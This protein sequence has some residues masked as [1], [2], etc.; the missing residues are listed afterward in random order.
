MCDTTTGFY[1]GD[2]KRCSTCDSHCPH[3]DLCANIM[4]VFTCY[5]CANGKYLKAGTAGGLAT[6]EACGAGCGICS[7]LTTCNMCTDPS[8]YCMK[9]W[10]QTT[11]NTVSGF[12]MMC[13]MCKDVNCNACDASSDTCTACKAGFTLASGKCSLDTNVNNLPCP[14][15]FYKATG[16]AC[17]ACAAGCSQC[18]KDGCTTC[19]NQ[20]DWMP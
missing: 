20:A 14:A 9:G 16:G 18:T 12:G 4:N 6:C 8:V 17:T 5:H 10:R 1:M 7:D 3:C 15:G 19:T 13:E 2:D 11:I